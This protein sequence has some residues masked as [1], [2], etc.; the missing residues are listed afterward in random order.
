MTD[1]EMRMTWIQ[2]ALC[3]LYPEAYV[4]VEVRIRDGKWTGSFEFD[5]AS[6]GP[7]SPRETYFNCGE[8][9]RG[10]LE[11]I[12]LKMKEHVLPLLKQKADVFVLL[13]N[14]VEIP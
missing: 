9:S 3:A 10:S 12:L 11:E 1:T 2:N 4:C 8:T 14:E 7:P 6:D 5:G 13:I